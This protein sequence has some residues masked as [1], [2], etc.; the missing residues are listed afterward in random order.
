[1]KLSRR[2]V[3]QGA[4][5]VGLAL[6]AGC[7]RWPGQAAQQPRN[8][9]R[10]GFLS[11]SP[12]VPSPR[13]E[14]FREGLRAHGYVEGENV[15]IEWRSAEGQA[16][17]LPLLAAELVRLPVDVFVATGNPGTVAARGVTDTIP[18]VMINTPNPV[19]HGL[20]ASLARPGGNVTGLTFLAQ[21][22]VKRLELLKESVPGLTRVV[23]LWDASLGSPPAMF[24]EPAQRLGL[25]LQWL[26]VGSRDDLTLAFQAAPEER[27]EG[28]TLVPSA[29]AST[30]RGLIAEQ[31]VLRQLPTIAGEREFADAGGLMAYGPSTNAQYRRAAY[32]VDR[33][34]K[35]T[36]PADLPVEQPREFE[37]VINLKTAHALGLTIPHHVLLQATEV[38]Q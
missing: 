22:E 36:K 29:I 5:T 38:I 18:I 2:Q 21:L 13:A 7:G 4:G 32:Y 31:A 1:M 17:Q 23:V 33:I 16:D 27:A 9:P 20:V 6:L 24:A 37:L 30:H 12:L 8:V 10:V 19:G 14:A 26:V 15:T 35:G 34:L 11:L 3:V 28:M 25:Q